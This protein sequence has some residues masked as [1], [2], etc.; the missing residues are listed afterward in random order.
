M[1][2]QGSEEELGRRGTVD[3]VVSMGS[4]M[5]VEGSRKPSRKAWS[6]WR[7][8]KERRRKTTRQCS[9]RIVTWS[10]STKPFVQQC[11]GLVR[12]CRMSRR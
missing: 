7:E 4:A 3:A 1:Y 2:C 12:M 6:W 11:R 5:V 9:C 8:V 10:R